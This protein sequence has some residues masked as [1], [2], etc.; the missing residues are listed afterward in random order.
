[1]WLCFGDDEVEVQVVSKRTTRDGTVADGATIRLALK[2]PA[3]RTSGA[4]ATHAR[5]VTD[6]EEIVI[7]LSPKN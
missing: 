2:L 3:D 6:L 1:M 4:G 7:P 5:L